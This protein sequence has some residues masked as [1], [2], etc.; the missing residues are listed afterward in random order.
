MSTPWLKF[1]PSDWRADPAL[2][3]C[4]IAARGLW[5]EMLCVMHEAEPYGS[6]RVNGRPVNEQQLAS[7]AGTST[8]AVRELLG[9]LESAGVFSWD[10]GAI[11]SRR[12]QRDKAKAEAD[13][14]NGKRGGNPGLREGVNPPDNAPDNGKD[15]AQKP[16]ARYQNQNTSSLRSDGKARKRADRLPEDWSI[17]DEWREDAI[18]AG[19][20]PERIDFEAARMRDWSRSS[21]NGTKSDWRAAWRNWCRRVVTETPPVR[22]SPPKVTTLDVGRRL[23][24]EMQAADAIPTTQTSG[25]QQAPLRLPAR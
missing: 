25:Y 1:Y 15:K 8:D 19:L 11:T 20:A 18:A 3:M 7:L 2:R 6:L 12:M 14:D 9:E 17:P 4:S 10:D 24:Q 5:M 13:R 21:A 16:E 22:G 23:L